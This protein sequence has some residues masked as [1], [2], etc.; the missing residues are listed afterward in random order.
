MK[1]LTLIRHAKSSWDYQVG[2]K[3]RP[4]NQR[5]ITDAH[6]VS[7]HLAKN[8][9]FADA[10]FSS[11]ANRALHTCTIFMRNLDISFSKLSVTPQLYDFSGDT[12]LPFIKGIDDSHEKVVIFGHNHAFT[13]LANILGDHF[14]D[15]LPTSGV[16]TLT[17]PVTRWKEI[18]KGTTVN[19]VFPKQLK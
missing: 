19:T 18:T 12:V 11:Y 8:P 14:I 16:V 17:F 15:N 9:F 1:T 13:H 4:L 6:L 2:D 7:S 3:D 5:G 10:V